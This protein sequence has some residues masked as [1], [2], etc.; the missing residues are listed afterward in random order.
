MKGKAH[1]PHCKE[2]V[3][4][5]VPD[6]VTGEQVATCPNC[7]MK[8]KVNVDE[9]YSWEDEAPMIHPSM[10][11][12]TKS[13]KPVIA[14][15]LLVMVFLSGIMVSGVL[16]FSFDSLNSINTPSEFVGTVVNGRGDGIEGINISVTGH[17]GLHAVTDSNGKFIIKDITSGKQKLYLTGEGYNSLTAEVFVLPWNITF[18][19]EKFKMTA[20][21]GETKQKSTLIK[22]LEFGPILSAL[23]ILF[24]T[25]AL[26]G[27]IMAIM[28][29]HY[30]I[31]FIGAIFG[32]ISGIFTIIGII[33]GIIALVL[34]LLSKEEFEAKPKEVKY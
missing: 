8:F 22:V 29:K 5:E 6:Y 33:L 14:G 28:R 26:V 15:I 16:L 18:P 34:L 25:V 11:L 4:V 17:P 19:Y 27:G 7:G 32:I 31:V 20:G 1:C 9:K 21:N 23:I 30:T 24:S 2:S 3:V 13:I 10:H 12:R